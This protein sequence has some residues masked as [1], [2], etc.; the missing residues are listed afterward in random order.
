MYSVWKVLLIV[1]I[2]TTL[3]AQATQTRI[4]KIVGIAAEDGIVAL[5]GDKLSVY[6]N[7]NIR[8]QDSTS[9]QWKLEEKKSGAV[10]VKVDGTRWKELLNPLPISTAYGFALC[11]PLN[12]IDVRT[13][14]NRVRSALPAGAKIKSLV[15][16]RDSLSLVVYSMSN[17]T[18][19]YDVRIGV[20]QNEATGGYSLI[21]D[22]LATDAGI[23]CGVQQGNG[24][25]FFV[26]ADEPSGSSD[27]SAVYVYAVVSKEQG[28]R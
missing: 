20:M 14:D 27:F 16:A 11:D 12:Q 24:D 4:Q 28:R 3:V 9:L 22:D 10:S 8:I 7:A 17:N 15:H 1:A 26:F 25:L 6:S 23:F 2:S 19:R 5:D 18:V 13:T 21:N